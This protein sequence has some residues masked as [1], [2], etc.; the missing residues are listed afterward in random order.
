MLTKALLYIQHM[1]SVEA[2]AY[3]YCGLQYIGI[4]M[5]NLKPSISKVSMLQSCFFLLIFL[6]G[7]PEK[8]GIFDIY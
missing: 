4:E 2:L 1:Y 8:K 5:T 7:G 3:Y 6:W